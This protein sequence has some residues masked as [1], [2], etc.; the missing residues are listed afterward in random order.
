MVTFLVTMS[1]ARERELTLVYGLWVP[2][3]IAGLVRQQER[4]YLVIFQA[5]SGSRTRQ[6]LMLMSCLSCQPGT[7][8]HVLPT[9]RVDLLS[10]VKPL[11]KYP[12]VHAQ[13]CLSLLDN[14]NSSQN[15]N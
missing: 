6:M 15:D 7:P 10:S 9:P 5:Q 3:T 11:W 13:R 1:K 14:S 8:E 4:R 12:H 2:Y